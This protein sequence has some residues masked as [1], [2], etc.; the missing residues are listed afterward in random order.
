MAAAEPNSAVAQ[1][2]STGVSN[3][4][5]TA[6]GFNPGSAALT[7][8]AAT[9]RFAYV[10]DAQG[11]AGFSGTISGYS[12]DVTSATTP[13]Q[14]LGSPV[15]ASTPQQVLLH[16]SG[17]LMY[18]L[19]SAG[20]LHVD[21]IN[22]SDGSYLE[23]GQNPIQGSVN[24]SFNVGVVDP[25]GR[26][27]YVTSFN[28][29]TI[30]GFSIT[31]TPDKGKTTNGVL[32]GISGMSGTTGYN[33]ATLNGPTWIMTDRAGKYVYVVNGSGNTVSE[34]SID[35]STGVLSPLTGS[36]TIPTG[37]SPSFGSTDVKGHLFVA[38]TGNNTVSVFT[39]GSTGSLAA[40]AQ[41]GG[42]NFALTGAS[43]IV[44]VITDPT[45]KYLYVLDST[46]SAAPATPPSQV[47]AF[48][49]NSAGVI[50]SQIGS[51]QATGT[52]PDGMA[53]DP[54]GVLMAI[55]N[56]F[57][58]TI[59]LFTLSTTTGAVAPATQSTVPTDTQPLFVVFYTA[60]SDQ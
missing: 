26:F 48:N 57:D 53:I 20:F 6:S 19:D 38:N 34:Y 31:Q 39:I 54:T 7:V 8:Q 51:P 9:A 14:S 52:A 28:D 12:V 42:T 5:A 40:V 25:T 27:L 17:D 55:D 15:A 46:T 18:Y 43:S 3:I 10:A 56:N 29:N 35:Q 36:T 37:A 33:D 60:A 1:G 24:P 49:L 22:P 11:G 30:F 50:G 47:F 21:D 2:L 23:T 59:S 41:T 4:T 44:N 13:V 58:N 32:T 16:P 45:G